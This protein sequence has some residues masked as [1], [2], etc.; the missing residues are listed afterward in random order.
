MPSVFSSVKLS[1]FGC[2][3]AIALLFLYAPAQAQSTD[4]SRASQLAELAFAYA[5]AQQPEQAIALLEEAQTYPGGDCFEANAWLKIGAAYQAV[6]EQVQADSFLA[7]AAESAAEKMSGDCYGSGT[8]PTSSLLNRAAEYSEA[9]YLDLGLQLANLTDDLFTPLT[10]AE[11]AGDYAEAD[12]QKDAEEI[13][14]Q[15]IADHQSSVTR[16]PE[17][18][19]PEGPAWSANRLLLAM[20]ASLAEADQLE[21][22]AFVIEQG[23]LLPAQPSESAQ[24]SDTSSE[25]LDVGYRLSVARLLITLGQLEQASSVLEA[26]VSKI[27]PAADYPL[28]EIFNWVEAAQLYAQLES[29]QAGEALAKAQSLSESLEAQELA[30]AQSTI[31]G[32]YAGIGD[33]EQAKTIASAIESV[34]ERQNAYGAIALA[35]A[36]S[37][38]GEAAE[39][40]LESIGNPHSARLSIVRAYLES[41]QYTEA[42]Q[43]AQQPDMQ[44][45]ALAEVG[46]A[47]CSAGLPEKLVTLLDPGSSEDWLRACAASEFA[48]QGEFQRALDLA[49]TIE[50]SSSRADALIDVASQYTRP[51]PNRSTRGRLSTLWQRWFGHSD[52][53]KAAEILDQARSLIE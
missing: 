19:L 36:R 51:Q 13:L 4:L 48:K 44:K 40:L 31:A 9:G 46:S 2:G 28:E 14:T 34:S 42:E 53:A 12:R 33:F 7:Q 47:Y 45:E 18:S 1:S 30:A 22:A 25:A 16:W 21:L 8:P 10:L 5:H 39:S 41:E 17:A 52:A 32:G 6:G 27:Q 43:I 49:Q 38:S 35:Y 15:A 20:A 23:D 50:N 37:G 26:A 24:A 3:S 29:D 11:I